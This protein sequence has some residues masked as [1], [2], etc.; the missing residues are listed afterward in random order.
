MLTP[1]NDRQALTVRLAELVCLKD[2]FIAHGRHHLVPVVEQMIAEVETQLRADRASTISPK[3][4]P[5]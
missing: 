3:P 4:E 1:E 5:S 2:E